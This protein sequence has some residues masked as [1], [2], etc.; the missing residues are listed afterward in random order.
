MKDEIY[1]PAMF[2]MEDIAKAD[3]L[4]SIVTMIQSSTNSELIPLF[5]KENNRVLMTIKDNEAVLVLDAAATV[6]LSSKLLDVVNL[7]NVN[8]NQHRQLHKKYKL[9]QAIK[10][11]KKL[12]AD[13]SMCVASEEEVYLDAMR[14]IRKFLLN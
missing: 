7:D 1:Q 4:S 9:R 12:E 2:L 11:I 10:N 8:R 5:D 6:A 14:L 3:S 13:P